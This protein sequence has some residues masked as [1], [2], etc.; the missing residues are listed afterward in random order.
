[1][2]LD[3]VWMHSEDVGFISEPLFVA[4]AETCQKTLHIGAAV[5][6]P[7]GVFD[8]IPLPLLIL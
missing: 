5:A 6:R 3:G 2:M 8:F 4:I 7:V 1:M